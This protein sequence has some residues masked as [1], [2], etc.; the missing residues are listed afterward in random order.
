MSNP[1]IAPADLSTDVGKFRQNTQDLVY[2]ELDPPVSGEGDYRYNSDAEIEAWLEQ[3]G[4]LYWALA[5][6]YLA[7]AREA[8]ME[9]KDIR[10][11]DLSVKTERRAE[12]LQRYADRFWALAEEEDDKS[13]LGDIFVITNIDSTKRYPEGNSVS[14]F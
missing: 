2:T 12:L 14:L 3:G 11:H 7:S 5:W 9:A 1:G 13:G 4:S 10:D 8:T 6:Y